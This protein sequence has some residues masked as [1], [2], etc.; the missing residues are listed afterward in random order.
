MPEDN[1]ADLVERIWAWERVKTYHAEQLRRARLAL[2]DLRDQ[3][4]SLPSRPDL[5]HKKTH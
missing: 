4:R 5:P 1:L 2:E 3:V